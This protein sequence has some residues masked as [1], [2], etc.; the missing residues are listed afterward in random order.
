M[1]SLRLEC[2]AGP[3]PRLEGEAGQ[4]LSLGEGG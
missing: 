3:G 2:E 4:D 1:P